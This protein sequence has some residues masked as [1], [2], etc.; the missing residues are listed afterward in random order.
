MRPVTD[1]FGICMTI[2]ITGEQLCK[3][4]QPTYI[5]LNIKSE[6]LS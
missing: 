4:I 5:I 2:T 6:L 3:Y 1:Y